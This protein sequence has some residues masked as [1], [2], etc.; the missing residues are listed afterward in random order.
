MARPSEGDDVALVRDANTGGHNFAWDDS[1]DVVF[2]DTQQHAVMSCLVEERAQWWAD[3]DGTHGSQ[4]YTLRTLTRRTPSLAE[5][6]ANEGVQTL[7]DQ[8]LISRF[9]ALAQSSLR[10]QR[11]IVEVDW[12]VPGSKPQSARIALS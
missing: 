1:G 6:Y 2:D 3:T 7:L 11:F 5:A 8:Q 12:S 9:S 10:S 4:L